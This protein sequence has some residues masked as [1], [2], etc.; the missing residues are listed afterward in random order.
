MR[1]RRVE[2]STDIICGRPPSYT[3]EF[4]MGLLGYSPTA[5]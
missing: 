5:L 4:Y 2:T 3:K 1:E